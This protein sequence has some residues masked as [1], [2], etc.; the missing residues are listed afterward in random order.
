MDPA[1]SSDKHG[2]TFGY[3]SF[4]KVSLI[5][6]TSSGRYSS[7]QIRCIVGL[8]LMARERMSTCRGP[9]VIVLAKNPGRFLQDCIEEQV[10]FRSAPAY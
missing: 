1:L 7:L 10:P 6:F 8:V 3:P 2:R 5:Y 9:S 4:R